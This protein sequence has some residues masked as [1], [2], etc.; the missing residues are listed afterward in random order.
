MNYDHID[1]YQPFWGSWYIEDT[2][3]KGSFS[4]VYKISK[5]EWNH[6]YTSALKVITIPTSD[7][8]SH[9]KNLGTSV[10]EYIQ[11]SID[12]IIN[13]IQLLYKLKGNSSI[14]TYEDHMVI[15]RTN[16][17]KWDILIR[18]EYLSPF[19]EFIKENQLTISDICNLGMDICT[20]IELCT[21]NKIIHRDIKEENI[22]VSKDK[23]FKLGDFG[24]SKDL[25]EISL[26]STKIGTPLYVAPEVL[27]NESYDTRADIYSLGIVLYKLL[28]SGRYPF[29]PKYPE[30]ITYSDTQTSFTQRISG[31]QLP[32]PYPESPEL[33]EIILKSCS[34]NPSNR[35]SNS[36]EFRTALYNVLSSLD[37]SV[38]NS[39]LFH[40]NF[41]NKKTIPEQKSSNSVSSA[42][43]DVTVLMDNIST[44]ENSD[45]YSLDKT[46]ST[47]NSNII[48]GGLLCQYSNSYLISDI[49]STFTLKKF[50]STFSSV[51]PLFKNYASYM[52]IY[53]DTL[54]YCNGLDNDSIYSF[55]LN[56][57]SHT[58]ISSDSAK[59]IQLLD[60]TIYYIN[61]SKNNSIYS[62]NVTSKITE[63]VFSDYC[64]S[65]NS[66][67]DKLY[68]INHSKNNAIY[69]LS[70]NDSN[71]LTLVSSNAASKIIVN[72]N[73]IYYTDKLQN[74]KLY[75][76]DLV[77]FEQKLLI[78]DS[79]SKFLIHDNY[80]FYLNTKFNLYYT[81]NTN[82]SPTPISINCAN[83]QISDSYLMCFNSSN[84]SIQLFNYNDNTI[85]EARKKSL[86]SNGFI[87]L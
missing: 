31:A 42:S 37:D 68:F 66:L 83:F 36:V 84:F 64:S 25:S 8:L 24:V 29:M 46:S 20:A 69:S 78:E 10:D 6:T 33:S 63:E 13:E 73:I 41:E 2:L 21:N 80:I 52:N 85:A 19:N 59:E 28:N 1:N 32:P 55:N 51:I 3:G 77:S 26:A 54:L 14:V 86:I 74:N 11:S 82:L 56:D 4:Q 50:D 12:D 58:K 71:R 15:K 7:M 87:Y 57:Y 34:Y 44:N 5:T 45:T 60:D 72:K 27:K 43:F 62:T 38:K 18:M 16:D 23:K 70:I 30:K 65:L 49:Y 61:T 40:Q 9:I 67:K 79:I 22:F 39:I 81:S 47:T 76:F 17:S 48:N 35:Y 53:K 75:F